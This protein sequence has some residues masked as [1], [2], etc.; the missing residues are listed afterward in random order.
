MAIVARANTHRAFSTI[1]SV[2]ETIRKYVGA[3]SLW[4]LIP[5]DR[6]HIHLVPWFPF[7]GANQCVGETHFP[8]QR[9]RLVWPGSNTNCVPCV[10]LLPWPFASRGKKN[11]WGFEVLSFLKIAGK[12]THSRAFLLFT[13]QKKEKRVLHVQPLSAQEGWCSP[14]SANV[15]NME[16]WV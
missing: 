1:L 10:C 4:L 16:M 11:S 15:E 5:V 8:K 2:D 14:I 3:W 12:V 7:A 9:C 13:S 6:I